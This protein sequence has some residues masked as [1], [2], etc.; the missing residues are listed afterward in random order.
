MIIGR[1][2]GSRGGGRSRRAMELPV[3][4]HMYPRR[5]QLDYSPRTTRFRFRARAPRRVERAVRSRAMDPVPSVRGS[6][7]YFRI[8]TPRFN[9]RNYVAPT[10]RWGNTSG[11]KKLCG[12]IKQSTWTVSVI[13]KGDKKV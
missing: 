11:W 4:P 7:S 13:L 10:F 9:S 12:L 2:G 8:V 6:F 5:R 1:G 3:Y